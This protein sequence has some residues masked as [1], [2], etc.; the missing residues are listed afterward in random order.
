MKMFTLRISLNLFNHVMKN[1]ANQ[2]LEICSLHL[3]YFFF[4]W[5]FYFQFIPVWAVM[6][7]FVYFTIFF[8]L[9]LFSPNDHEWRGKN[10]GTPYVKLGKVR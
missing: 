5:Y 1:T 2:R 8:S 9:S 6:E 10:V 4:Q 7:R 3:F